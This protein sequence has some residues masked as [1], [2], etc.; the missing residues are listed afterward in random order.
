MKIYI[1]RHGQTDWNLQHRIQGIQDIPLNAAGLA[2][3]E[4]LAA[5]MERRPVEL[6]FFSPLKRA[7]QTAEAVAGVHGA[8]MVGLPQLTEIAYGDWEGRTSEDIMARDRELYESWWK[9]PC[10]VAPPGGESLEAV[11]ARCARAWELIREEIRRQETVGDVAVVS[12]G[13]VLAHFMAY[14]L[15]EPG[16]VVVK[17]ASIT[18]VEYDPESGRCRLLQLND[19]GHLV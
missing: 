9:N 18:T 17:N 10:K 3:A 2:Q 19:C 5:A 6:V 1:I 14:I 8:V 16:G 7:W 15:G 13:G 4:R 11:D 12:H